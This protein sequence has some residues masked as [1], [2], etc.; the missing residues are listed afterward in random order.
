MII[1]SPKRC[2]KWYS[3]SIETFYATRHDRV[4]SPPREG[5][6]KISLSCVID[7]YKYHVSF[8]RTLRQKENIVQGFE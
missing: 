8:Y 6:I 4:F 2:M 5:M 1:Y 3:S 7:S